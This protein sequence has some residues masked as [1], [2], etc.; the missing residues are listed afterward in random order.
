[1]ANENMEEY[2][3]G[4]AIIDETVR[5]AKKYLE[6][7]PEEKMN[8]SA[9]DERLRSKNYPIGAKVIS[10]FL[11]WPESRVSYSLERLNLEKSGMVNRQAS[12]SLSLILRWPFHDA[13]TGIF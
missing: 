5:V 10:A 13:A 11:N 4:P 7:H 12:F 6:E 8:L 1:M 3:T 2:R 9:V